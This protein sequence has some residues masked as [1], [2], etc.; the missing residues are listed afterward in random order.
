V[1]LEGNEQVLCVVNLS[2]A[3][4]RFEHAALAGAN[5]LEGSH[6]AKLGEG[7]ALGAYGRA[8]LAAS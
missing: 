1:R 4:A 3:P 6:L 7:L 5:L 8:F 2:G